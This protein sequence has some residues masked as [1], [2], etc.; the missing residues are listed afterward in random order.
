[1][2]FS[3]AKMLRFAERHVLAFGIGLAVLLLVVGGF[4][5]VMPRVQDVQ[6]RG[7][8]DYQQKQRQ[9]DAQ[10]KY[11]QDL[12]ALRDQVNAISPDDIARLNAVVPRGK[13]IPGIF[14]QMQSFANDAR[15]SLE[16]VSVS[17]SGAATA[18]SAT[19]TGLRSLTVS[20]ILSGSLDYDGTKN[21][22]KVVARQAPLLDLTSISHSPASSSTASSYSFSFRS[23][24]FES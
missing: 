9:Y 6:A 10:S 17:D 22:L 16:S 20:V 3:F 23:Y 7:G 4:I 1:M 15:M 14:R 13:D 12:N 8:L 21:F 18:G 2:K 5:F 24:Y 11:L 19:G